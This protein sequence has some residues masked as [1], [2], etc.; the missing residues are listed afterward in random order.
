MDYRDKLISVQQAVDLVN[1]G[2]YIVTGLGASTA[3]AFFSHLH[4][5]ADRLR[6]VR[7]STCLPFYEYPC[8]LD[9]KYKQSFLHDSWFYNGPTRKAQANGTTSYVPNHLHSAA[10]KR[11]AYR[12]PRIFVGVAAMPDKHGNI[13]LSC[14]N[15]Y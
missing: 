4:T 2:D 7:I 11:L 12:R 15:T 14:S 13:S 5:A 8:L 6:D 1:S 9:G 3:H 10:D